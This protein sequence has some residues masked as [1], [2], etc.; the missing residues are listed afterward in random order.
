MS[1][2][3]PYG[4]QGWERNVPHKR[5]LWSPW[6]NLFVEGTEMGSYFPMEN[7]PLLSL[8]EH[9]YP[10]RMEP[11]CWWEGERSK[12]QGRKELTSSARTSAK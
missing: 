8:A 7:T 6:N 11:S 4:E 1:E 3:Y 5:S 12:R 10:R 9:L 2:I